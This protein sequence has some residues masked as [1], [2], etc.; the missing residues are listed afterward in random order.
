MIKGHKENFRPGPAAGGSSDNQVCE[1]S[2]FPKY[3]QTFYGIFY[4]L[5]QSKN[6]I[7]H[8]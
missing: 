4:A 5:E 1:F 7:Q 6:Y 2:V 3:L 8:L